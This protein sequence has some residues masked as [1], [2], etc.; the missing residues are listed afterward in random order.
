VEYVRRAAGRDRPFF[1]YVPFN[2]PH[3]PLHAPAHYVDRF[4]GLSPERRIMAAMLASMDEEVGAILEELAR[5][6]LRENTFVF[7]QSDNGPSR[8]ARN[9]L[10]GRT[11]PYYG[12]RCRLKGHKFSLFEGGIRSPA[13]ASWPARI[14]PG[15]RISEAGIAMDLFPT[16]LRL[17]GGDP[18][19]RNCG[20]PR[21]IVAQRRSWSDCE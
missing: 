15:L 8:E 2:A 10:D 9:R 4:R 5:A 18:G 20:Q 6:G 14:P 11:D 7:F 21:L 16:F 17:A 12:S 3:Y 19:P 13:I 1:L